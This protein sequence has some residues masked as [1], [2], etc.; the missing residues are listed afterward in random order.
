MK[1]VAPFR[2]R[3]ARLEWIGGRFT[4]PVPFL[5]GDELLHSEVVLWL[6]LPSLLLVGSTMTDPRTPISFRETLDA[7]VE[8]PAVDRQ[9]DGRDR[10]GRPGAVTCKRRHARYAST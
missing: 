9:V 6:E 8:Q 3:E 2:A 1:P 5:D 10:R 4:F 7:A